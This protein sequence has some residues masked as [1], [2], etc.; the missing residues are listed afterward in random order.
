MSTSSAVRS[1]EAKRPNAPSL[2]AAEF[3]RSAQVVSDFADAVAEAPRKR[4]KLDSRSGKP[5]DT[6]KLDL[7]LGHLSE[8][9]RAARTALQGTATRTEGHGV[10]SAPPAPQEEDFAAYR[11]QAR[12]NMQR[13]VSRGVLVDA[14]AFVD[15]RGFTK[16]ALSKALATDRLFYLEVGGQRYYPAFFID[17]RYERT[18]VERVSKT[19]GGLPGASKLQFF[20]N[21]RGSLEGRTP[22]QALAAG[23]YA[24]VLAAAEGFAE[25]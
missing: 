7:V 6:K 19:L 8:K 21:G 2:A 11:E 14:A 10:K 25:G 22:L 9:I 12:A 24:Q 23:K 5:V 3:W 4:L 20:L 18:K 13:L 15:A 17:P 1:T 16:Q